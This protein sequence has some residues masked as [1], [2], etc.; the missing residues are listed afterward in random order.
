MHLGGLA[1]PSQVTPSAAPRALDD[2]AVSDPAL[3][4]AKAAALARAATAGLPVL[5][6]FV[7]TTAW[8]AAPSPNWRSVWEDL[9]DHGRHPSVV[10]SSSPA[11]ACTESSMAG[12]F[13]SMRGVLAWGAA[14]AAGDEVL[15]SRGRSGRVDA[16][17]AVLVQSQ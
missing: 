13:A 10:R 16:P 8:A 12:L 14:V 15:D 6:G 1:P 7:L 17:M 5:P 2:P 3:A 11:E 4:G 9:S